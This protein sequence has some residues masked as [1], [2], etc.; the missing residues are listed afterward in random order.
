MLPSNQNSIPPITLHKV[1][2]NA[3]KIIPPPENCQYSSDVFS[4]LENSFFS[5]IHINCRSLKKNLPSIL[6]F[7]STIN[8]SPS[9]IALTET[10]LVQGDTYLLAI[11]NYVLVSSPRKNRQG[12]GVGFYVSTDYLYIVRESFTISNDLIETV[13]IEILLKQVCNII[14]TCVY[15]PPATNVDT[16][17]IEFDS[18]LS[19]INPGNKSHLVVGD[20]NI[21]L[22]KVNDHAPTNAFYNITVSHCLTPTV[23]KPTRITDYTATLIDNIFIN[24]LKYVYKSTIF[25]EDISDHCPILLELSNSQNYITKSSSYVYR[26]FDPPAIKIFED[27]LAAYNWLDFNVKCTLCTDSNVLYNQFHAIFM[28]KYNN[29]FPEKVTKLT[30]SQI[31]SPPWMSNHLIKCCKKK[32]HLL[33]LCRQHATLQS[34]TTFTQYRSVLKKA[35][36]TAEKMYY[37]RAFLENSNNSKKTWSIINNILAAEKCKSR[38]IIISDLSGGVYDNFETAQNFNNYFS[39]LGPKLA[40][41][42]PTAHIPFDHYLPN[43]LSSAIFEPSSPAEINNI[44]HDLKQ[45]KGVGIDGIATKILKAASEYIASPLSKLMNNCI[46]NGVFPD[47]LKI[48][49]VIPVFKSGERDVL[50]NYRPISILPCIS[51]VFEKIISK[52]LTDYFNTIGIPSKNQ[53]GFQKNSSTFMAIA[54]VMEEISASVDSKTFSIGVFIDLAKAFDTVDH[55]I[56]LRKLYLYGIRGTHFDL[57]KSYLSNRWQFVTVG[58]TTSTL[59]PVQ[60]GV[61]QGSILGPLLFLIYADDVQYCSKLLKFIMFADDTNTFLSS[62]NY[63]NLFTTLNVEL[64][65]LSSWFKANK[66]SLN[67]KK[68]H[69][70]IFG[71]KSKYKSANYSLKMD[72][73]TLE[74]VE[75]TKFLGVKIDAKLNWKC[76]INDLILKISRNSAVI[77]K[78][79]YKIN[80]ATTLLLY[81]TLILPHISY[82]SVIWAAGSNNSKLHKI[83]IVQKRV[84][85]LVSYAHRMSHSRPIFKKLRRLTIFDIYKLQLATFMYSN[86]HGLSRNIFQDPFQT[87]FH[88]HSVTT[89][90]SSNIHIP[91]ARTNIRKNT[92]S[93]AGPSLWNTI[94]VYI[95]SSLSLLSFKLSFKNWLFCDY[96]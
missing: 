58:E 35:I 93:I 42:I 13:S 6:Q 87:N 55:S 68:T 41:A 11:P 23:T 24:T 70:I 85:R 47:S 37:S 17:N 44:I 30:K 52:R 60:C 73:I 64:D 82:C 91:F 78:I 77:Y 65:H 45:T 62:P 83:L 96:L 22:L 27:S 59:L 10:W 66:L 88:F 7:L 49:N 12:G 28:D 32:A 26:S 29:A 43:I 51:K 25:Y 74:Q 14:L 19:K 1:L 50:S 5:I 38:Q 69:Y 21:N 81:D 53:F 33:R 86:I 31:R 57:L 20:Y 36:K 72:G 90:S 39:T 34:K 9:V 84:L 40:A 3:K 95:K 46:K 71:N 18:L 80:S 54:S 92:L 76:H 4:K 8:Y 48:A 63:C 79:R 16:F 94:P 75:S 56:L 2:K 89:R 15:R 67:I 61:P